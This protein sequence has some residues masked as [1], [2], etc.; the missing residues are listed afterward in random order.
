MFCVLGLSGDKTRQELLCLY[1]LPVYIHFPR[2]SRR[3]S[4]AI[5]NRSHSLLPYTTP[6]DT[7]NDKTLNIRSFLNKTHSKQHPMSRRRPARVSPQSEVPL[8]EDKRRILRSAFLFSGWNRE[9]ES[10]VIYVRVPATRVAREM[11]FP[12]CLFMSNANWDRAFSRS[13]SGGN[14]Q[15][16]WI[17]ILLPFFCCSLLALSEK[18][19]LRPKLTL[20]FNEINHRSV[21]SRCISHCNWHRTYFARLQS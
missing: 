5:C 15:F 7:R 11:F 20:N 4:L 6:K 10:E 3:I 8:G 19:V 12:R 13:S 18:F 16:F 21:L 14:F 9:Q 17:T 2:S 1:S